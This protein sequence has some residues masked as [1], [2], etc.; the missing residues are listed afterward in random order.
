MVFKTLGQSKGKHYQYH[1][2][3]VIEMV[4]Q[5]C[6]FITSHTLLELQSFQ[7]E[8]MADPGFVSFEKHGTLSSKQPR[9]VL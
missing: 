2:G 5:P 1:I 7:I 3:R 8:I 4:C 6:S 9:V